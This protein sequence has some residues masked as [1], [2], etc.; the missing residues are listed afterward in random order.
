MVRYLADANLHD[1]IVTG[2]LRREPAIDF[3]SANA[4]K[5][6][7]VA[8]PEVLAVAASRESHTCHV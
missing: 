6:E 4:A 3:L 5:L 1:G 7:G 8:D 2:S